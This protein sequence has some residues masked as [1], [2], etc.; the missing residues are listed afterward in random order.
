MTNTAAAATNNPGAILRPLLIVVKRLDQS[1]PEKATTAL[2]FF[3]ASTE[4]GRHG[5]I[6][7]WTALA[8]LLATGKKVAA[9]ACDRR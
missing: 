6:T 2:F 5:E 9:E 1:R 8:C 3:L 4:S 7:A